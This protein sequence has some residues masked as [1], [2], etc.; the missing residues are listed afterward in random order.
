MAEVYRA[1]SLGVSGFEKQLAIKKILPHYSAS[2]EFQRMFEYEARLSSGLTHA[3]IVQVFDLQKVFDYQTGSEALLLILEFVD[4]K[5]LRQLVTRARK[6]GV[7][8]PLE[9]SVAIIIEV[10]KGLDYAHS[11]RDEKGNPLNLIHRDMSPQNIMLAYEGAVKIVDFG[12]AKAKDRADETRSGVL[13]GKF[14]YMSPEQAN[15][16]GVD[17]RTDIFSTG[18]ILYELLTHSRLFVAENDMQT[19]KLIQACEI[20]R[21]TQRNPKISTELERI[22]LKALSK[23]RTTRYAQARDLQVDLQNSVAKLGPDFGSRGLSQLMQTVFAADIIAERKRMDEVLHQSVLFSQGAVSSPPPRAVQPVSNVDTEITESE[24]SLHTEVTGLESGI[25]ALVQDE[26]VSQV[27]A[28]PTQIA[29]SEPLKTAAPTQLQALEAKRFLVERDSS[30]ER[31]TKEVQKSKSQVTATPAPTLIAPA[32]PRLDLPKSHSQVTPTEIRTPLRKQATI[33]TPAH[34]EETIQ[35]GPSSSVS[36]MVF[37]REEPPLAPS[38]NTGN[39]GQSDS[40]PPTHTPVPGERDVA[41]GPQHAQDRSHKTKLSESKIE[42]STEWAPQV[43][44][45]RMP[46]EKFGVPARSMRVNPKPQPTHRSYFVL[47][48]VIA[49]TSFFAFVH[50]M[51]KSGFGV[52]FVGSEKHLINPFQH[53]RPLKAV[54]THQGL[55]QTPSGSEVDLL[56]GVRPTRVGQASPPICL[57]QVATEPAQAR[58]Q[59]EGEAKTASPVAEFHVPCGHSVNVAVT[60]DGYESQQKNIVLKTDPTSYP[61]HLQELAF[62][63]IE[64]RALQ[65]AEIYLDGRK[66]GNVSPERPLQIPVRAHEAH[67][68]K[69]MNE[70]LGLTQTQRVTVK[71]NVIQ[72][73]DIDLNQPQGRS[74]S[75]GRSR[76][77]QRK[78]RR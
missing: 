71:P 63:R 58:V 56:S 65:N 19:L 39:A 11:K 66:V 8:L 62:G 20:E 42:L 36:Q 44:R 55:A 18:I 74:L 75:S 23:D 76:Q 43:F 60:L 50:Y 40:W 29:P 38:W 31:K 24:T 32:A 61:I 26:V 72:R 46:R 17:H 48:A 35:E 27:P 69:F 16:E 73:L 52:H 54:R 59:V 6:S 37:E 53:D 10:C 25:A 9:I 15:G 45:D 1:K 57:L 30:G 28:Q 64:I 51:G 49:M 14:G 4:G 3:N 77:S 67:Q 21:P 34:E 5:N 22:A 7:N 78:R 70:A 13:K 33:P 12:I 41:T 47:A 68:L 2:D